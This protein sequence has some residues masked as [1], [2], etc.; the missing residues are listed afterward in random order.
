ML[1]CRKTRTGRYPHIA[2]EAVVPQKLDFKAIAEGVDI[3][4]VAKHLNL[5]FA[6]GRAACP[7]CDSSDHPI[8]LFDETNTFAC[9]AGE[10]RP[11]CK[12]LTGDCIALYAHVAGVGQYQAAKALSELFADASAPRRTAQATSPKKPEVSPSSSAS[13]AAAPSKAAVPFDR[14][15]FAASLAYDERVKALG[16]SE[17]NAER[18]RIGSKRDKLF[19]PICPP[20]AEPVC[21]AEID[22][23][24]NIRLP[25]AWLG[26]NVVRLR[27][28]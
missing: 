1:Q 18:H 15:K 2:K 6:K 23:D 5:V 19:V 11:G 10:P 13:T 25:D 12:Y 22:K 28:A 4:A 16:L 27:R 8:E 3:H 21:W 17:E 14:V 9:Y 24:G 7:T 20:D 26:N